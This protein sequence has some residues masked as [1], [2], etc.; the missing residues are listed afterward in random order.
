[1]FD[2][3]II[4]NMVAVV[5]LSLLGG[6][7]DAIMRYKRDGVQMPLRL[8]LIKIA[9]DWFLA[10]FAGLIV[11]LAIWHYYG[12]PVLTPGG[13]IAIALSGYLGG[14]AIN[15]FAVAWETILKSKTG[16][17]TQS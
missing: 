16:G 5:V 17:G 2:K 3:D 13:G 15:I 8:L 11:Y 10:A 12:S 4:L 7:A 9:A 1:M 6:S 14:N